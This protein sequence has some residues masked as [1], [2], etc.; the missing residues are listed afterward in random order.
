[1]S[2]TFLAGDPMPPKS[3]PA[4]KPPEP[5]QGHYVDYLPL[6]D[7]RGAER[8]PKGHADADIKRSINRHGMAEL[9]LLDERTGRLI[10]GHGRLD[11]LRAMREA[12]QE[13]PAGVR[14]G[15]DGAWLAPILRGWSSRSDEEAEAYLIA[16]NKLTELGGWD[17]HGLAEMLT[18]LADSQLL[19][20]TGFTGDDLDDLIASIQETDPAGGKDPLAKQSYQANGLNDL[21]DNYENAAGR[22]LVIAY[23]GAQYVWVIGKLAALIKE[24]G[25]ESNAEAV[26]KLIESHTGD[27]APDA[28]AEDPDDGELDP[29]DRF[30]SDPEYAGVEVDQP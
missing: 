10:A 3:R 30:A 11:Q 13:P 9:P 20:L 15:D 27:T 1:M 25:V 29:F 21:K 23:P 12:G 17:D 22:V 24:F 5:Q 2:G 19:E 26:L 4:S 6:D 18:D 7:I 28:D 16:S 14:V 8:N